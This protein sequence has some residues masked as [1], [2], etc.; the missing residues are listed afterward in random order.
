MNNK[1]LVV[2]SSLVLSSLSLSA[3]EKSSKHKEN[4][5]GLGRAVVSNEKLSDTTNTDENRATTNGYTLFDLGVKMQ[6]NEVFKAHAI[7]RVRNEFG[8]FYGDGV[9]F[10]FR[11]LRLGGTIAKKI[12]YEIGDLDV[13]LTPYTIHNYEPGFYDYENDL[14]K[15]KREIIRYE[16]F[17]TDDN[18]W[19]MQG[20]NTDV[21]F[22]FD[23]NIIKKFYVR[24]FG[25]RVVP[26]NNVDTGDRFVWGGKLDFIGSKDKH[27]GFNLAAVQDL[28]LTVP[29]ASINYDN[30]VISSDFRYIYD[31]NEKMGL[32]IDGEFG[33]SNYKMTQASSD[34]TVEYKDGFVDANLVFKHNPLGLELKAG[35][36][37]VGQNFSSPTAQTRRV[38]DLAQG[39]QL[40]LY[41]T[42][43]DG[44]TERKQS[45]FDRYSQESGLY[46]RSVST[47]LDPFSPIYGNINP[48]GA[49][50][51]RQGL[52][53]DARIK[54]SSKRWD[55]TAIY[56]NQQEVVGQNVPDKRKF[57]GIILGARININRFIGWNKLI[58]VYGSYNGE[59]T[60]R[61][62]PGVGVDL[63]T[64]IID[65]SVDWE[66]YNRLHLLAGMKSL[67]AKGYEYSISRDEFNQYSENDIPNQVNYDISDQ[68]IL[69]GAKYDFGPNS[70][71]GLT[72]QFTSFVDNSISTF[73]QD[74]YNLDQIYVIYQI[75]F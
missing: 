28:A 69:A 36:K 48:Y 4:F 9:S 39:S 43:S 29:D 23:N 58:S 40:T 26:T 65:L 53:I 68:V 74:Q 16:N 10:D 5:F 49:T 15:M 6:R 35:Y 27:I 20:I 19:R 34:T 24:F 64:N 2:L 55:V 59:N 11:E 25:N 60:K 67:G 8:G 31:L 1:L 75:K 71:L 46:R 61:D 47:T 17:Y 63:A 41:P 38:D 21:T 30:H 62:N 72:A 44:A 33:G 56:T 50:P 22:N 42:Y 7:L 3:Q 52:T 70:F 18:T 73:A 12:N 13:A 45:I 54:D 32:G 37:I 51:N 66:V 57:S 14:I